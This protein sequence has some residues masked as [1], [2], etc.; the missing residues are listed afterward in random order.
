MT[1]KKTLRAFISSVISLV[2]CC[3]MLLGTTFAWFTDSVTSTNNIITAGNLDIELYYQNDETDDWTKVE[4]DSNVFKLNTLWEPGHTEVVKL[5]VVNEG[6]LALKYQLGVNVASETGSVNMDD[7]SF[8]LSD[9]IKFAIIDGDQDYTREQAVAA[10]EGKSTALKQAYSSDTIA[11]YPEAEADTDKPMEKIVT[12]VVY[13]PTSVGNEA[14]YGKNRPVPQINLGLN[15]FANQYTYEEDSFNN[16]YDE[17]AV[18]GDAYVTN[19]AELVEALANGGVI[20]LMNDIEITTVALAKGQSATINMNGYDLI[21]EST[22]DSGNQ[23]AIQVKGDLTIM[24]EG[25]VYMKHTGANMGWSAL[26]AAI[27]VEGGTL[28]LGKGVGVVHKG[29]SDMAYAVDVNSTPGETI[30]NV[31]G[32]VLYSTYRGVRL[33]NNNKT[34]QAIVNLNSGAIGGGKADIWMQNPSASAV[35]A[36]GVVNIAGSYAYE[37]TVQESPTAYQSRLYNFDT[38][39]VTSDNAQETFDNLANGSSVQLA[40]GYDYGTIQVGA[41]L[42]LVKEG[43]TYVVKAAADNVRL[44]NYVVLLNANGADGKY[45]AGEFVREFKDITITGATDA[46][47]DAIKFVYGV[48]RYQNPETGKNLPQYYRFVEVEDVVIDAVHF[49]DDSTV[50]PDAVWYSPLVLDLGS[51]KV[52]GLTVQNCKL[53]GNHSKMNFV[54]AYGK[55][56]ANSSFVDTLKDLNIVNNT[57]S[58]IARLCE[59]RAAED[60]TIVGN[61]VSDLNRELALFSNDDKNIDAETGAVKPYSGNV[62]VSGNIADNVATAY[63]ASSRNALFVRVGV[64]GEATITVQDNV[65]TNTSPISADDFVVVTD[66]TGTLKVENNTLN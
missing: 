26:T 49:T 47:V 50:T 46:M 14:N 4:T 55:T 2:L 59:L 63:T 28:T 43:N 33:F 38:I 57:V 32:A 31:N 58:G 36:N 24:G 62:I 42:E 20:V 52:D 48:D 10:A 5:K 17:D 25:V 22:K 61:K 27:S 30:L 13:M 54:Y 8:Q 39:F 6:T 29:G 56:M 66:H 45:P 53:I 34:A 21:S 12:M 15:L 18:W 60:V 16:K 41:P 37:M 44:E 3:S 40:P 19:E 64:G 23:V 1:S 11:L 35:D 65:I 7:I 51:V 9:F